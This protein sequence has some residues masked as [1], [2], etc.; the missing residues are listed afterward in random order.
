MPVVELWYELTGTKVSSTLIGHERSNLRYFDVYDVPEL[1]E[2][3]LRLCY[4]TN[5]LLQKHS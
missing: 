4:L 2:T 3:N 5:G 1:L